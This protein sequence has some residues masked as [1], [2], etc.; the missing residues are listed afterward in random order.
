[1]DG[2]GRWAGSRHLPRIEGH[3]RGASNVRNILRAMREM[4]IHYLT[5]F[6][7]SVE[8]WQRP[9]E[10]IVAL[11]DLLEIFLKRN[12]K[13]LIANKIRLSV[14]GRPAE[15]PES[16]QD[17]LNDAIEKTKEFNDF[18]LIAA[19]NY[20]A[21]TEVVD[22]VRSYLKAVE[23]GKENPNDLDWN[24]FSNYL[25]TKNIPDPDLLIRTSGESR[26][27]NFLLMQCAYS[28]LYFTP[29]Y[30]PDFNRDEFIKA[31]QSYSQRERRFGK[32]GEQLV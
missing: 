5:L 21:R 20:G 18:H 19:L 30:W 15:L 27:S 31:I 12:L 2:N 1:M 9:Q 29:V 13:E 8:N 10:E 11:M 25:Y 32:T 28:E 26:I 3:R 22:A 24:S 16:V 6:A 7:F 14:I 23:E 17:R 4:N